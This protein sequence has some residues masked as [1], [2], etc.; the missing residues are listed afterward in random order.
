MKRISFNVC[1][2]IL[3]LCAS[4]STAFSQYYTGQRVF[5]SKFP[6]E[7]K[8]YDRD[9]YVKIENSSGDIIVAIENV[10]TGKTIQHAYILSMDD[11]QF[12]YIP[13]GSYVCKYM[14]TDPVTGKRMFEKDNSYMEF[15]P[16]EYGGYV[17]T[18][19]ETV[20]GNLDQSRI[21][22]EDFFN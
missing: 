19:Q 12:K 3:M 11:Y 13:V 14:W 7:T 17:I 15:K 9:N 1:L 5:S 18:M 16:N 22:E 21:D 4:Q 6:A 20:Y 2:I 10:R 8:D